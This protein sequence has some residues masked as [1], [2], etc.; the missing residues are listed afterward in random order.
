MDYFS[1]S[2]R[3]GSNGTSSQVTDPEF[4]PTAKNM[5][6]H[7]TLTRDSTEGSEHSSVFDG[8]VPMDGGDPTFVNFNFPATKVLGTPP[9]NLPSSTP[10]SEN[11]NNN[12]RKPPLHLSFNMGSLPSSLQ[13]SFLTYLHMLRAVQFPR[14]DSPFIVDATTPGTPGASLSPLDKPSSI[15]R[16]R[17]G[18]SM[19]GIESARNMI[20]SWRFDWTPHPSP[21]TPGSISSLKHDEKTWGVS[22]FPLSLDNTEHVN[23]V[24]GKGRVTRAGFVMY[25]VSGYK[26]EVRIVEEKARAREREVRQ[27]VDFLVSFYYSKNLEAKEGW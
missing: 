12:N 26:R 13:N 6:T 19:T 4:T 18:S 8:P 10:S 20:K 3:A 17:T 22:C 25:D 24:D 11:N 16:K 9:I 15:Y 1:A 7:R 23:N 14:E 5:V 21:V 2:H 27:K